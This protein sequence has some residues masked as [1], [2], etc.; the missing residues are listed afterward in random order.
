MHQSHKAV[1]SLYDSIYGHYEIIN[2]VLTLGFDLYWRARAAGLIKKEINS[3]PLEILDICC[4]TGDFTVSLHNVFG[5]KSSYKGC[6][7]NEK[8]L[9]K[10]KKRAPWASFSL[11][12][13]SNMPFEDSSFDIV[14]IS[15]ATRN[16]FVN[17]NDFKATMKEVLRVM[18]K[19]G[20]FA[21]LETTVPESQ[22]IKKTMFFF[23]KSTIKFLN[24]INP[25]S[26]LPYTFLMKTIINFKT[27]KE[28]SKIFYSCGFSKV[29]HRILSPGAV[30]LHLCEK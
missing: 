18:K 16:I 17:E 3:E 24:L 25:D 9:G 10:A 21:C 23:V 4:G 14:A 7:L 11:S 29:S 19:G 20:V 12:D 13:C 6:D 1:S 15:F 27:A 30:A 22:I 5:E 2:S 28:L 8:M 26:S